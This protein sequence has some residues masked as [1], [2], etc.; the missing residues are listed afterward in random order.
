MDISRSNCGIIPGKGA[1][2]KSAKNDAAET[3]WKHESAANQSQP[4]EGYEMANVDSTSLVPE[5]TNPDSSETTEY[6]PALYDI[7]ETKY[8]DQ[9]VVLYIP[10]PDVWGYPD[11]W[12]GCTDATSLDLVSPRELTPVGLAEVL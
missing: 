7:V 10:P 12:I 6:N 9:R 11:V 5:G 4:T 2:T 3:C 1:P 8:G